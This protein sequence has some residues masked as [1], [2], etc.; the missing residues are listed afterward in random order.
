MMWRQSNTTEG[1][2]MS[3][4]SPVF[5]AG[6][7]CY[8]HSGQEYSYVTAYSTGHI[9]AP[10]YE[11]RDGEPRLGD[12][13]MVAKLYAEPLKVRKHEECAR[14]D[15]QIVDK[16]R[17]LS[18]LQAQIRNEQR[19]FDDVLHRLKDCDEL[20]N[21]DRFLAGE[22][23]HFVISEGSSTVIKT[24]EQAIVYEDDRRTYHRL[25]SLYG[26]AK[27]RPFWG[28]A[29]YG[30]G[31]GTGL[32]KCLPCT[33]VEEAQ[34]KAKELHL[35]K[36]AELRKDR[37]LESDAYSFSAWEMSAGKLGV[38]V[39]DDIQKAV[40]NYRMRLALSTLESRKKTVAN[41]QRLLDEAQAAVEAL[42]A[43]LGVAIE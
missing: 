11:D 10:V 17:E 41:D 36:L 24:F 14:L 34:E 7:T 42:S 40:A 32:T 20:V 13:Y 5:K 19:S 21:I 16:K 33:S 35:A 9:A 8:D 27:K 4:Q 23:T 30:D 15:Q 6:D 3:N 43:E 29:K 2:P 18:D 25:L 28:I 39:P 26:D 38:E 37:A 1:I 31:S 12:P 22:I